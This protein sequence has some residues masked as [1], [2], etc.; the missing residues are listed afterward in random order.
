M[1]K[2]GGLKIA[3]VLVL[4]IL[5]AA[6]SI[7]PIK[8]QT[9]L[10]L[11][12]QGGAHVV[13]QAIP[14]EGQTITDDDMTKLTAIMRKRI[15]EFG[16]TEPTI[17]R[18]GSDRLIVEMAGIDDPDKAIE[19]LGKTAK[20]EFIGPDGVVI[21]SGSDLKNATAS[22]DQQ[23]GQPQINLE[24]TDEG[25]KKFGNA[26]ARF[27]GQQIGIYLDGELIQ[28]PVVQEAILNGQA[29]ISGGF[30]TIDDALNSAALLRGGAL[31]VNM[32]IMS[33]RTVGPILGAESLQ[34]SFYA[35]LVGLVLLCIFLIAYYRLP[36]AIAII[37]LVVYSLIVIWIINLINATLTLAGIAGFILSIG[38]A[39]DANII[40]YERIK[41]EL[42][43]GK[44]LSAGIEAGFKRAFSTILD[45]NITTLIAAA[46][47][48]YLGTGTIKGFAVILA[49][50]IIAS[51]FTAIIFTRSLLRWTSTLV[52]NKKLYGA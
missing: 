51:M 16:V 28:N 46:V 34:K 33:K 36:G 39:V 49:I 17:Q 25:T 5:A 30:A 18:E 9:N 20:L 47:L 52:S 26:T 6:L 48:F 37:S 31:P 45:S 4:I 11:D 24:F 7:N 14:D 43:A 19:L 41:E 2:N 27:I 3:V 23:T 32:E 50:G 12:L 29:R 42:K 21:L 44:S 22:Y 15:D 38:M 13:L 1:K 40:I 10:G 35:A 8:T